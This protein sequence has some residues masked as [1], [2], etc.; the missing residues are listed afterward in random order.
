MLPEAGGTSE[1]IFIKCWKADSVGRK[2]L[3][4]IWN[5]MKAK[6]NYK[7][8]LITYQDQQLNKWSRL[9]QG[10]RFTVDYIEMFDEFMTR[11]SEF[12]DESLMMTLS[13]FRSGLCDYLC[14]EHF[15]RGVCD[16]ERLL[17]SSEL[18]CFL[19]VLLSEKFRI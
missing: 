7:Y 10:T 18:R 12:V 5:E 8:F 16:L 9:T 3:I 19:R 2:K 17:D 13:R 6:L 1:T 4:R 14:R 11:C 15:A